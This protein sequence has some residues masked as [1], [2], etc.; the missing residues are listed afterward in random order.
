MTSTKIRLHLVQEG[1]ESITIVQGVNAK[2]KS[3]ET[4]RYLRETFECGNILIG[5]GLL[6]TI[7]H[8]DHRDEIREYLI[9]NKIASEDDIVS[10]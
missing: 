4:M 8:G 10:D 2:D 5:K 1:D 9:H 3:L 6:N 7:V